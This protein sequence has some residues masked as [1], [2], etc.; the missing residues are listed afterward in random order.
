MS[1]Q[2]IEEIK[3]PKQKKLTISTKSVLISRMTKE[4]EKDVF[5]TATLKFFKVNNPHLTQEFPTKVI[6][7]TNTEKIRLMDLNVSYYLEG[8][9]IV[10]NDLEELEICQ[11]DGSRLYLAGKQKKIER[12]NKC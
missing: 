12:R 6:I 9:D 11:E 5:K 7:F 2:K 8:N 4:S 10:V 1:G 3:N